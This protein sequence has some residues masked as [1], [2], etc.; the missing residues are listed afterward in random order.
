MNQVMPLLSQYHLHIMVAVFIMLLLFS[1]KKRNKT[2][3][4]IALIALAGS[5]LYEV[6][7]NEPVS[8]IPVR[9]N[10]ALN[11]PPPTESSNLH[12]YEIPEKEKEI[13]DQQ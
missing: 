6:I 4:F 1:R 13:L 8:R 9:I 5:I 10:Q 3:F 12:Y 2:L 7:W 11:H